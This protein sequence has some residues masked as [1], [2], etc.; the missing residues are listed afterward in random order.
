M[1]EGMTIN[2]QHLVLPQQMG[3]SRYRSAENIPLSLL[4]EIQEVLSNTYD[5]EAALRGFRAIQHHVHY[6]TTASAIAHMDL[7]EPIE[8]I[9][10]EANYED[11]TWTHIDIHSAV[12]NEDGMIRFFGDV[13]ENKQYCLNSEYA[14]DYSDFTEEDWVEAVGSYMSYH[15]DESILVLQRHPVLF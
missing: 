1:R 14:A 8:G 11:S 6:W 7:S 12:Q 13:E 2:G 5:I 9:V 3:Y 10:F 4:N 15:S